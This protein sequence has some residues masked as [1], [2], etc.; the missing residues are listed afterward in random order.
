MLGLL[1]ARA[2]INALVP[3]KHGDFLRDFRDDTIHPSTLEVMH[4]LGLFEELLTR[5][6]QQLPEH[7]AQMG[8]EE[9]VMADFS[10]LPTQCRF[11]ALMPQWDFL[12]FLAER[13]RR[14]PAFHLR[15]AREIELI[16]PERRSAKHAIG[17]TEAL[18]DVR[19]SGRGRA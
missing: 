1:L 13:A 17:G 16:L 8:S 4:E 7:R 12:N 19:I 6:Y 14:Y 3:E 11:I 5:P 10:W 15:C 2:G 18:Y 9:V